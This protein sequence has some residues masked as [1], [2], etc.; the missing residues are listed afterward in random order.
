MLRL[1]VGFAGD[2][3]L[4]TVALDPQSRTVLREGACSQNCP[5][6]AV[7]RV[8][9]QGILQKLAQHQPIRAAE[10]ALV[11]HELDGRF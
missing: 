9:L 7:S 10:Q 11:V 3:V 2:G 4:R 5:R 6:S 8:E 1:W